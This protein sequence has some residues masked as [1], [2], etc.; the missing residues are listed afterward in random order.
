M[1]VID[2]LQTIR[3]LLIERT[4]D[5]D[6]RVAIYAS[7]ETSADVVGVNIFIGKIVANVILE[8]SDMANIESTI[9]FIVEH[10]LSESS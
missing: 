4:G 2:Y 6:I 10:A 7:S 5:S 1:N 9:S 3:R 8:Q